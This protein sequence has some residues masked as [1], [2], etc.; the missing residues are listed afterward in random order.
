MSSSEG[1][2]YVQH[3]NK[4]NLEASG[5]HSNVN[6]NKDENESSSNSNT[7]IEN[8]SILDTV[9]FHVELHQHAQSGRSPQHGLRPR[10][11]VHSRHQ[12]QLR[13][14]T[15]YQHR[16]LQYR[17]APR[18]H[19]PKTMELQHWL[20]WQHPLVFNEDE[21]SGELCYGCNE[22]VFV[23]ATVVKNAEKG[24][25]SI[26]NHVL[27]YPLGCTILH[28]QIILLFSSAYIHIMITTEKN[29]TNS[30]N[31]TSAEKRVV[32]T[33]I[34]VTVATSTLTSDVLLYHSPSKLKSMTT[35]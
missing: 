26:I 21:R 6:S 34:V 28:T 24:G 3:N 22:P 10:E 18:L 12:S 20:H 27:N 16:S 1:L 4:N 9:P 7:K 23:M 14:L 8:A 29:L 13:P 31:A 5:S 19:H 17:R 33:V 15:R 32:N 30:A 2:P 11:D 25:T 35:N